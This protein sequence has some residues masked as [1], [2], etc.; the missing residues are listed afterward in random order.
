MAQKNAESA[1]NRRK[2]ADVSVDRQSNQ[3]A[4]QQFSAL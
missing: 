1:F 2:L 4:L 3:V